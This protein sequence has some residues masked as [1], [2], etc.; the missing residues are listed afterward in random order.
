MSQT[1]RNLGQLHSIRRLTS[2]DQCAFVPVLS[3]RGRSVGR[4]DV[5]SPHA[6]SLIA[7]SLN[8]QISVPFSASVGLNVPVC[9]SVGDIDTPSA[10]VLD[11]HSKR[12]PETLSRTC[13][14]IGS[15]LR[16]VLILVDF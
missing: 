9:C 1:L 8:R 13:I 5:L 11:N 16:V 14:H 7:N 6:G 10:T 2:R 12:V 4:S 3:H 15:L